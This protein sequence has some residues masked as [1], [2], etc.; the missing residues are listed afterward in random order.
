MVYPARLAASSLVLDTHT[1]DDGYVAVGERGHI[2]LSSEGKEW[3][4]IENV[5]TRATLTAVTV[6]GD[7]LWAVGH[8][9][10]V[11]HSADAGATWELQYSDPDAEQP[12]MDVLFLD[13]QRGIAIG[14]YSLVMLTDDG[15]ENWDVASMLDIKNGELA[16]WW[17]QQ[18]SADSEDDEALDDEAD[19][20]DES[21]ADDELVDDEWADDEDEFVEDDIEYHLN[22]IIPLDDDQLLIAGEAGNGYFSDDAGESWWHFSF[23]YTGS[24]FGLIRESDDCIL[25]YGL[26]G[27]IQRTC[28]N[29]LNWSEINNDNKASLFGAVRR[30]GEVI[31]VGSNGA[32]IRLPAGATS[33]TAGR[34]EGGEDLAAVLF[35]EQTLVTA[36]E[37]GLNEV[38]M[39]S[40]EGDRS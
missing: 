32:F 23:P 36:G 38:A 11:L 15:G 12:L 13:Q 5:P 19:A 20:D 31:L 35:A 2:L 1:L 24:M 7:Q 8:D 6:V 10:V 14:A 25:A 17:A 9:A 18:E 21:F 4:Q 39:Q 16:D 27:H 28:D 30:N 33:A 37:D 26:R 29:G 34:L 40:V 22:A 3:R